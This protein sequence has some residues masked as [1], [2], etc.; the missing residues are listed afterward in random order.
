M[1]KEHW[2]DND[3]LQ[4]RHVHYKICST[5]D[6]SPEIGSVGR[7]VDVGCDLFEAP[8]VPLVVA[9]PAL[10]RYC[11]FGNL[12]ARMGIG[13]DGTIHRLDRHPA[14]STHPTTPARDSDLRDYLRPQ[15]DRPVRLFDILQHAASDEQARATFR[16]L[17]DRSRGAPL[18]LFDALYPEHLLLI[19]CLIDEA[20][21]AEPL[22]SVGSSGVES[23]LLAHWQH[24]GT[25]APRPPLPS[26]VSS[27]GPLLVLSGSCSPVTAG[28]IDW[29]IHSGFEAIALDTTRLLGG[30]PDQELAS[31]RQQVVSWLKQ[32]HSVVVH[33][34]HGPDD[35]RVASTRN[36]L[37]DEHVSDASLVAETTRQVAELLAA[38]GRAC[39]TAGNVQRVCVA[40][41]DTSSHVAR[42]LGIES[43]EF[44][45]P[46]SPGA[47]LCRAH[48]GGRQDA[49]EF[50]FKGGQVGDERYFD[51][52]RS[53]PSLDSA[54]E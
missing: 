21:G 5:F 41:G 38:V 36:L 42:A 23:A 48:L 33:T 34:G 50:N 35:P 27:D 53:G 29:A 45:A 8:F 51:A 16:A 10:G 28:Q 31:V 6:S 20:V 17:S 44:L 54:A 47:P 32:G 1:G 46:L 39:L 4:P 22:F 25:V 7:A 26:P 43:L 13:S 40:G 49:L 3:A 15:T 14:A 9:A 37:A 19:G 52:V 12:F 2:W 18:V 30:S 11:V 24:E